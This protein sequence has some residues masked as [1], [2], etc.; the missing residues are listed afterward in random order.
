LPS[1]AP[2][3]PHNLVL[4]VTWNVAGHAPPPTDT[5]R[6]VLDAAMLAASVSP[7]AAAVV[8][9]ALEEIVEMSGAQALMGVAAAAAGAST[10]ARPRW[11]RALQTALSCIGKPF[12]FVD[13]HESLNKP[14]VVG[15]RLVFVAVVAAVGWS[16][17]VRVCSP[18]RGSGDCSGRRCRI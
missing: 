9:I 16:A 7:G 4:S 2:L 10:P 6:H 3:T 18:A 5:L 11:E 8:C 12:M 1:P 13:G 17:A 15:C 14:T